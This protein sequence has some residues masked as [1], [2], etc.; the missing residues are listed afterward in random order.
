VTESKVPL[1]LIFIPFF[2]GLSGVIWVSIGIWEDIG[3]FLGSLA[4]GYLMFKRNRNTNIEGKHEES[5]QDKSAWSL[6]ITE[7][8]QK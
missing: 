7:T 6:N 5:T 8:K 2:F 1:T 3:L 4:F